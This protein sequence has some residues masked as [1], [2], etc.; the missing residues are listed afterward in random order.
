MPTV[1]QK[2]SFARKLLKL[3]G[4]SGSAW[5]KDSL[6]YNKR[7]GGRVS[8]QRA[9]KERQASVNPTDEGALSWCLVGAMQHL[10]PKLAKKPEAAITTNHWLAKEIRKTTSFTSI[11]DFNDNDG[12]SPVKNLLTQIAKTGSAKG[13]KLP[14]SYRPEA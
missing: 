12:W 8:P 3:F 2:K 11:V 7:R 14:K 13:A 1:A 5:A 10:S 4:P 9:L 6:A